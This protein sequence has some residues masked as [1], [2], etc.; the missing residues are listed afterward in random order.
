[1]QV[2]LEASTI[3]NLVS[4]ILMVRTLFFHSGEN[5]VVL[6]WLQA[7]YVRLNLDGIEDFIDREPQ[8]SEV[9][10]HLEGLKWIW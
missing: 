7:L 3:D 9:L 10:F 4:L 6:C 2:F 5:R 1:M 8:N